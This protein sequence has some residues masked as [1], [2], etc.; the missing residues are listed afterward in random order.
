MSNQILTTVADATTTQ[1]GV[2]TKQ[3][4]P[5]QKEWKNSEYE[6][7]AYFARPEDHDAIFANRDEGPLE[8]Q[9][10]DPQEYKNFDTFFVY[11]MQRGWEIV[12]ENPE[13]GYQMRFLDKFTTA[14]SGKIRST[15][16]GDPACRDYIKMTYLSHINLWIVDWYSSTEFEVT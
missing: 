13:K 5:A 6:A 16:Y 4:T 12:F 2:D 8:I 14:G 1:K 7:A 3:S 10:K 11:S 9:I 15:K